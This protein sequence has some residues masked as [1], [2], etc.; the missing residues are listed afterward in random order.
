MEILAGMLVFVGRIGE[1]G[2]PFN[3]GSSATTDASAGELYLGVND[4]YYP[5]NTG[6]WTVEVTAG[7]AVGGPVS[8]GQRNGGGGG[9]APGTCDCEAGE[10]V[11]VAT[12]DYAVTVTHGR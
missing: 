8:G 6:S 10:P 2:T 11:D 5:D 9:I 12:G 3:V 4:N 1:D 7:V